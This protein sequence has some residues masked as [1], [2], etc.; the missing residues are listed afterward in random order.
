MEIGTCKKTLEFTHVLRSRVTN[1]SFVGKT[2]PCVAVDEYL[3]LV[4]KRWGNSAWPGRTEALTDEEGG[5]RTTLS[6]S[7]HAPCCR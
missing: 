4:S 6:K 7:T 1:S 2:F 5:C 3:H